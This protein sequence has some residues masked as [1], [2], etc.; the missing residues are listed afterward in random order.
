MIQGALD[1][2]GRIAAK[3]AVKIRAALRQVTDFKRV[4]EKYQETQPQPTDNVARDRARAR[5]WVI[6]NVYLNDEALDAAIKRSWAEAYVLGQAAA[7]EWI[8]KTKE[9]QKADQSG[10]DWDNWQPGDQATALL[11]QPTGGFAKFL[12]QSGGASFFKKFDKETVENLGTALSDSIAAGLDAERAAVMIGQHVA[13]PV[14]ALTIA[15]TEQNR[16]MSFGSIQRYKGAELEKMEWHVSQPCD[17]CAQN[18]G[19]VVV[20]GQEFPSNNTQPPAHPHCRCVLLPVIPG[21]EEEAPMAGATVT[22]MPT[23]AAHTGSVPAPA[24]VIDIPQPTT[25]GKHVPGQWTQISRDEI[26]DSVID[27]LHAANP[28]FTREQIADYVDSGRIPKADVSLIKKGIVYKNG[29]VTV[30]FYSTGASLPQKVKDGVME[31]V[32]RLQVAN[33]V[34]KL[35]VSIGSESSTK[36]GWAIINGDQMWITPKTARDLSPNLGEGSGFKMP[37][38]LE[39]SQRDYT[40]AHEWGHLIDFGASVRSGSQNPVTTSIIT[41]IVEENPSA[42]R[43]RYSGKNTKEFFAEMFAE[44]FSTGGQTTNPIVQAMAKEF[45]WKI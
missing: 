3:N 5:S 27:R 17:K 45:Q 9:M 42:F 1:A 18:A 40:L 39:V 37:S 6:L 21:M 13:N 44:W 41:R 35:T 19:V 26:R 25:P 36:H 15:I 14:R 20:I 28:R 22:P 33:P 32:D 4:F 11:L 43:S 16:A 12:E 31:T 23:G 8:N 24:P 34:E 7:T 29:E 30:Q 2:D 38:L 10:I